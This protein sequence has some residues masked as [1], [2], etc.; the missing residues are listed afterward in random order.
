MYLFKSDIDWDWFFRYDKKWIAD[1]QWASLSAAAKTVL[2]VIACHCNERGEAFPGED[3]I[4]GLSGRTEKTVRQGISDLKGFPGFDWEYYRTKRGKRSK[5]FHLEFPPI[6]ERGRSF[7]FHRA[8]MDCGAWSLLSPTAQALYPVLR[9]FARFIDGEDEK[10]ADIDDFSDRYVQRRWEICVAEVDQLAK[11]AGID[12]HTVAKA[13]INLMQK[14][15]IDPYY[16]DNGEKGWIVYFIPEQYWEASYHN[17][18]LRPK[19]GA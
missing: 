4:A 7:F 11:Y 3:T 16:D 10:L 14:F 2:P 8:I 19:R 18:Q 9:Y 15:L 6:G 17:L 12:R 1:M 5:K 13:A